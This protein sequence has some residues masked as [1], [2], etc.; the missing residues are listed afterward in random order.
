[1]DDSTAVGVDISKAHLDAYLAPAGKAARFSNDAA[2]FRALIAWIDQPVRA[3]TYEPT[4]HWHRAFE[5]ALLDAG[6]PLVRVNPLQARRFAQAV[7]Q[8]AKTDAVDAR[9]LAQ[10]GTALDLRPTEASSPAQRALEELQAARDALD[11]DRIATVNRQKQLQHRLLRRQTKNGLSQLDRHSGG[12]RCRDREALGRGRGPDPPDRDPD[13]DPRRVSRHRG[14]PALPDA[15]TRPPR[16]QGGR[17]P[18]RPCSGHSTIRRL[19]G[20]SFIQGGRARVRRLLYMPALA[21]I[22]YNPD[23]RRKYR[24]LVDQGKPRK[25]A[26]TA[27]MRKLLV[28]ANALLA[29][30]RTW[31]PDPPGRDRPAPAAGALV[32]A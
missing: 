11:R 29:Q 26:V 19:A 20:R 32:S 14:R 31:L 10:M 15:G 22:C 6:L 2:G 18:G 17:Q 24:Q 21:A 30:D 8:R 23:L 9:M 4:G 25:V 27:V 7:G 3:V 5:E 28:L 13:V 1:M 12:H 16:R